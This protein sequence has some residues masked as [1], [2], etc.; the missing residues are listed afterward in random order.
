MSREITSPG[1][2]RL[3]IPGR[4]REQM[5]EDGAAQIR[6]D[7]L[8]DPRH[9]IEARERRCGHDRDDDEHQRERPVELARIAGSESAVDDE[10]ESLP[11]REHRRGRDH[12]RDRGEHN[13]LAI[14]TDEYADA[15]KRPERGHRWRQRSGVR[16]HGRGR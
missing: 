5:V 11:D 3:V 4:Q 12:E 7:A 14:G 10:L 8:P 2:G 1:A 13:L 6:G 16:G 9:E 15:R